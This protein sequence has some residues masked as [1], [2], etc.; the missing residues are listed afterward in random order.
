MYTVL[1][2]PAAE[3][4]LAELWSTARD[5]ARLATAANEIDLQLRLTPEEQ[6]ESRAAG[7][8]ILLV[9]PLGVTFEVLASDR[10]VRVLDVWSFAR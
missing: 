2:V 5:R 1:W 6:G 7:R 4:E 9:A 8:R 10:I 3:A